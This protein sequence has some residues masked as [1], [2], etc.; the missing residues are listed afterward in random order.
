MTTYSYIAT[1]VDGKAVKGVRDSATEE[2]LRYELL[3]LNLAVDKIKEKK[4]ILQIELAPQRVKPT[5]IMHFSRQV[6]AF[7]R[8]GI[9]ITD[10]LD[11]VRDGT[12]NK[13]WQ[14]IVSEMKDNIEAGQPFAETIAQ[15][16]SLFPPYYLAI[17]RSA[18]LTGRLDEAL[19]QLAEYMERDLDARH[20]IKSALTYPLVI[21]VMSV[22][23]VVIMATFVL[24]RFV[25]FFKQ[26]HSK[27]PL[28]TRMLLFV[29]DFF[30][31]FWYVTPL[32]FVACIVAFVWMRRSERGRTLRDRAML[33]MPLIRGVVQYAVIERFA[34]I[35]GAMVAAG[36]S[37][38]EAMAGAIAAANNRVFASRLRDA[39]ERMLEGE[40][41]AGPVE[42]A[43]FF[44][45]AAVQMMRVG[46]NTGTLDAQLVNISDYYGRELEFR[47]KKLTSLFEPMV[48][49]FMGIIVGFVAVALISAM[50]GVLNGQKVH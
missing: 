21:A 15:Y 42:Q 50:Y 1:D 10:A 23:T 5:E 41:L 16:A 37:L 35:L 14:K 2:A 31:S 19:D 24:P 48:I 49:V 30:K 39:Q 38:P 4:P 26:L 18:E 46:E 22:I 28:P 20:K 47:L 45:V 33:S 43:D 9:S 12:E 7:V 27:L 8:A 13:R 29:A 11:V 34:R 6:A 36:V 3:A 44:P 40:G 25:K 17:V 32:A